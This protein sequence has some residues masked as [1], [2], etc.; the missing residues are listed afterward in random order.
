[1]ISAEG[2]FVAGARPISNSLHP[3]GKRA[4]VNSQREIL[5]VS[6]EEEI[7]AGIGLEL[8]EEPPMGMI[9]RDERSR[10][11]RQ[12]LRVRRTT[13]GFVVTPAMRWV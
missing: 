13:D 11:G 10:R 8:T 2:A 9:C 1:M 5:S 12:T 3:A 7:P 4:G 6:H